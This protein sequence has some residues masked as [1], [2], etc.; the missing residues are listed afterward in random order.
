MNQMMNSGYSSVGGQIG[1]GSMLQNGLQ[2]GLLSSFTT[3]NPILDP[4]IHMLI[5]SFVG[6]FLLNIQN[7]F[8]IAN[9]KYYFGTLYSYVTYFFYKYVR[10]EPD[11]IKKEMVINYITE[12]KKINH[13]YTAV[14][15][16]ISNKLEVDY[17]KETPLDASFDVDP[18][19]ILNKKEKVE[20]SVRISQNK[21]KSFD[22]KD[23]EIYYLL[24]KSLITVYGDQERKKE[25]H[26][27]NLNTKMNKDEEVDI[28]KEFCDHCLTE[29]IKFRKP[30]QWVQKIYINDKTGKWVPQDSN[31]KRK[32]ETVILDGNRL[33]EF[34]DD[35]DDFLKSEQW[36][37]DLGIPYTRGYLL[38]GYPGT[39]KTSLIKGLSTYTRRHMHYLILQNVANDEQLL[40]LLRGIDY[41]TTILIIEDI[42]CMSDIIKDRKKKEESDDIKKELEQFKED[43][44]DEIKSTGKKRKDNNDNDNDNRNGVT[45]FINMGGSNVIPNPVAD[46]KSQLTLSGLLNGIDGIFNNDGRIM[47]MTTNHPE[48]LDEALVRPGR[49]DQKIFFD[50]A[51]LEQIGGIYKMMFK[52]DM[53]DKID[54]FKDKTYSPA[55]VSSLFLQHKNK[56]DE[57]FDNIDK[58]ENDKVVV[59]N[60]LFSDHVIKDKKQDMMNQYPMGEMTPFTSAMMSNMSN[61]S[62]MPMAAPIPMTM[63]NYTDFKPATKIN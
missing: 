39:G 41:K 61:M 24:N 34:K 53:D 63:P 19:Q 40:E 31:N 38:Y 23:H 30:D 57:I 9:I 5:Y 6:A 42:D 52:K 4:I 55:A 21:W 60:R 47:I 58:L 44:L 18:D 32:L 45:R 10:K 33:D 50:Y 1:G 12:K 17:I 37:H 36:Y 20:S 59:D 51:S 29:Y 49:I 43:L 48:V 11:T 8:S 15:W 35:L 46:F 2:M 7:I 13:L 28:L 14:D 56:P 3:G 27:I 62:N 26:S 16:Y 25:N 22:F 54:L